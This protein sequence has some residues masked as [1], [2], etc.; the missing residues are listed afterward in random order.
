VRRPDGAGDKLH[1]HRLG[2]MAMAL[3]VDLELL[4]PK[5]AR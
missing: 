1:P 2:Y 5:S 3:A 4:N